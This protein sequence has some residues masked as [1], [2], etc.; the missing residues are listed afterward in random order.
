M[1]Q[2]VARLSEYPVFSKMSGNI[3]MQL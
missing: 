1:F 3:I 2:T